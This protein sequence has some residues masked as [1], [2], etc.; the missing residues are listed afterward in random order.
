MHGEQQT[1]EVVARRR[2]VPSGEHNEGAERWREDPDWKQ[3]EER[4]EE[5]SR[6]LQEERR[7]TRREEV[8]RAGLA[9]WKSFM[10]T[11]Q[12]ELE[13]R[14]NGQLAGLL[15]EALPGESP[16]ALRRLAAADQ[17]QAEQDLV[18]L[19]KD[20]KVFYKHVEELSEEDMPARRAAERL[21]TTWLKERRDEWLGGGEN[22]P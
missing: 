20:G 13:L 9:A 18:T 16:A 7:R 3:D 12:R 14:K 6:A 19:M 1:D 11:E 21:R 17:R 4:D 15:G 2:P 10:Q 5:H 8:R 22:L